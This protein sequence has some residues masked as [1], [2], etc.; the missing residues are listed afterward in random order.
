MFSLFIS[1]WR[2]AAIASVDLKEKALCH[3]LTR[4][5]HISDGDPFLNGMPFWSGN[6]PK[7]FKTYLL[8]KPIPFSAQLLATS[9]GSVSP[10][11][12]SGDDLPHELPIS[13][14][15]EILSN[16]VDFGREKL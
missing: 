9:I 4:R 15:L 1:L 5:H 13:I 12:D 14:F 11:T 7:N 3:P 2:L 10:S 6:T 16:K 8:L